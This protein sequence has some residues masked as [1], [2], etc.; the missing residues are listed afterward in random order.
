MRGRVSYER[1]DATFPA[2]AYSFER[3]SGQNAG[4][5]REALLCNCQPYR[6]VFTFKRWLA[7]G[8]AVQKG[9]KALRLPLVKDVEE[10]GD[11]GETVKVRRVLGMSFVFCR[12]QVAQTSKIVKVVTSSEKRQ[13]PQQQLSPIEA[14]LAGWKAV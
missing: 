12:C 13:A 2:D 10:A 5:V 4:I 7:Q 8:Y 9:Q 11:D 6:D 3:Y 14:T 1:D